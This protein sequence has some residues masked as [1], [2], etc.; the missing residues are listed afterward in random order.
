MIIYDPPPPILSAIPGPYSLQLQAAPA[1]EKKKKKHVH[2]CAHIQMPNNFCSHVFMDTPLTL[3]TAHL[4]CTL[5]YAPS[6]TAESGAWLA[7]MFPFLS[8]RCKDILPIKA[9]AQLLF[10]LGF[11]W[12][13]ADE[14]LWCFVSFSMHHA[15]PSR[16]LGPHKSLGN[17][18]S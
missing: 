12:H 8:F 18:E 7:K 4:R 3:K 2:T 9:Q 10:G 6:Y 14:S 11:K 5:L 1:W 16:L 17:L 13:A 15:F